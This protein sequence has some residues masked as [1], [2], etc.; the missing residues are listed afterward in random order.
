MFTF[1]EAPVAGNDGLPNSEKKASL[2][3]FL[4]SDNEQYTSQTCVEIV[5][6]GF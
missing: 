1:A 3:L 2:V 6:F 5:V 4:I